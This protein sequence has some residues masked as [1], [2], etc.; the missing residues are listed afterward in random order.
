MTRIYDIT[1]PISK[2]LPVYPGDPPIQLEQVMSLDRGDIANVSRLA[3]ST[4]IGTHVDPP[5][6]FI[7]GAAPLDQLPLD[8]LI[9]PVRVV[10]VGDVSAI[11]AAVLQ[12]CNL[13]GVGRVL[14]KTRNSRFW[15]PSEG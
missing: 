12:G 2:A 5:S 6:H 7:A 11:D 15:P 4:H 9:G 8:T 1:V 10:D 14:F 3:C 13:D